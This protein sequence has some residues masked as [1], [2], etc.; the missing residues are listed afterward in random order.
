[1]AVAQ[2]KESEVAADRVERFVGR[3]LRQGERAGRNDSRF[4]PP[5]EMSFVRG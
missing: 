2:L 5:F 3:Y 4:G 1:V